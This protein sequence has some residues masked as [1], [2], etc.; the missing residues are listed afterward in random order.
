MAR[1]A[2]HL[3][4][5]RSRK[6]IETQNSRLEQEILRY[7]E[8]EERAKQ[9]AG[10]WEATFNSMTDLVSLQGADF[11]IVRVNKAF[12]DAMGNGRGGPDR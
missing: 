1:V 10:Q 6:Q 9:W 2:M 3:T 8:A 4:I 11:T 12:A 5:A 7:R